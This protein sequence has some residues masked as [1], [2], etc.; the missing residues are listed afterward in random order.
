MSQTRY[1]KEETDKRP[2]KTM[3]VNNGPG[4]VEAMEKDGWSSKKPKGWKAPVVP[5]TSDELAE[6]ALKMNDDL[7]AQVKDLQTQVEAL[8]AEN[9]ALKTPKG[10]PS[11]EE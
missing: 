10:P 8:T 6:E 4:V 1:Y 5:A 3:V 7:I 11:T 9:E 2:A